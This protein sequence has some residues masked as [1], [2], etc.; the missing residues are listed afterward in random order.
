MLDR[1]QPPIHSRWLIAPQV[2]PSASIMPATSVLQRQDFVLPPEVGVAWLE[3]LPLAN[4]IVV[5]RVVHRFRA[6]VYGQL[7]PTGEF[8]AE[9]SETSL[10]MES[11]RGGTYCRREANYPGEFIYRPGYDHISH[12][13]GFHTYPSVDATSDSEMTALLIADRVLAQMLGAAQAEQLIDW[14]GVRRVPTIKV[15][16]IPMRVSAPLCASVSPTL[17]GQLKI[18]FAQSKVLEYLCALSVHMG[19]ALVA[20]ASVSQP[21]LNSR[22][23]ETVRALHDYL[24]QME[25]KLPSLIELAERFGMSAR[26]L[27]HEFAQEY[28]KTIYAFVSEVRLSEAQA[29]LMESDLS[30]KALSVRL[31]Y[32][33]VNHFTTAFKRKFGY[34]P[35]SLRRK[36]L[37]S[38]GLG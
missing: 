1:E 33:H 24:A 13:N 22:K 31:G 3:R 20:S 14:L 10:C 26:W 25:G 5:H 29:A 6:E 21:R 11:V 8:S 15:M 34:P 23:R 28:G 35:G 12:A 38:V 7:V 36:G 16:A 32:S 27:N 17:E 2:E 18:L 4:G 9:Y 19:D 30:I 37:E